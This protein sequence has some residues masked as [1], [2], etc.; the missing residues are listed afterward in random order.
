MSVTL[1]ARDSATGRRDEFECFYSTSDRLLFV[2]KRA[3][4]IN[5]EVSDLSCSGWF[6]IPSLARYHTGET[7]ATNAAKTSTERLG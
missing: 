7:T 5:L 2:V 1:D 4:G 6:N 3:L